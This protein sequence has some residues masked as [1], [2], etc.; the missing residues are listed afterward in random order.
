MTLII[1]DNQGQ[2]FSQVT[3]NY[4]VPQGGV[5]FIEIEVPE[6]K[7]VAGV[8]VSVN[9]HQVVLEDIPPSEVEQL[10]IEMAQ[11]NTELFEMMLMLSGGA[12]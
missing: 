7:R 11:A 12:A 2:I 10:R 3:G 6:D 8:D 5:Q 4:L 9:P 1:Y